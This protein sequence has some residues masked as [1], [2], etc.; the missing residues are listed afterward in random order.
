MT[1]P[2]CYTPCPVSLS[3]KLVGE[4]CGYNTRIFFN[5]CFAKA[6]FLTVR[7]RNNFVQLL[8]PYG[9]TGGVHIPLP[10]I[11]GEFRLGLQGFHGDSVAE[12]DYLIVDL[13]HCVF[14]HKFKIFIGF[15]VVTFRTSDGRAGVLPAQGLPAG[16]RLPAPS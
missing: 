8:R 7:V 13:L 3:D 6:D 1:L 12:F 2:T 10:G 14:L 9:R 5:P 15:T 16:V 4:D 11:F